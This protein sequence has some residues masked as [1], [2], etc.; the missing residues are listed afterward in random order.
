MEMKKTIENLWKAFA[1]ESQVRNKYTFFANAA[2]KEGFK[3][4]AAIFEETADNERA[5]AERIYEFIKE[6]G[7]TEKNLKTAS[8]G[9]H[10]E[11]TEMYPAFEKVARE[12]GLKEIATFRS[13]MEVQ[14][15]RLYTHRQGD[16]T[17]CCVRTTS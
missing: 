8:A 15:L 17:R 9:E 2:R 11:W 13:K 14:K 1:G 7:K 16:T 10:Y 6:L 12:E 5:H 3:Q 4:I